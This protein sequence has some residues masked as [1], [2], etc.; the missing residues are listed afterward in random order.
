MLLRLAYRSTAASSS[1]FA[2]AMLNVSSL[3]RRCS[4]PLIEARSSAMVC[5]LVEFDIIEELRNI[6]LRLRP[7]ADEECRDLISLR[8]VEDAGRV[9][10]GWQAAEDRRRSAP[11]AWCSG[12]A[13]STCSPWPAVFPCRRRALR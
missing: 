2:G 11:V 10:P 5:E 8:R 9:C 3:T 13:R 1:V 12:R 6:R 4:G 7:R